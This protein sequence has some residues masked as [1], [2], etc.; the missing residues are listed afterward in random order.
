MMLPRGTNRTGPE[1]P[2]SPR[3]LAARRTDR[4]LK[5]AVFGTVTENVVLSRFRAVALIATD[6]P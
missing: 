3:T 4:G 5:I 6:S 2:S 1:T